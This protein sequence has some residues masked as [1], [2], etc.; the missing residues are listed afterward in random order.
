MNLTLGRDF[1]DV[2]QF[3]IAASSFRILVAFAHNVNVLKHNSLTRMGFA[4][5]EFYRHVRSARSFD[6]LV[7]NIVH[8]DCLLLSQ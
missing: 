6:V 2:E 8:L 5:I 1:S 7:Q 4:T 3:N